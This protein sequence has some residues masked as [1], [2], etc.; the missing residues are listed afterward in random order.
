[1]PF[2]V[3]PAQGV[4][5]ALP[6]ARTGMC[7]GAE[8][9]IR[10]AWPSLLKKK[11]KCKRGKIYSSDRCESLILGSTV[12]KIIFRWSFLSRAA[13][14]LQCLNVFLK[15]SFLIIPLNAVNNPYFREESF[16]N[17]FSAFLLL[18]DFLATEMTWQLDHHGARHRLC[19]DSAA[20]T[21]LSTAPPCPESKTWPPSVLSSS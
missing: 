11:G 18:G 8:S 7:V 21:G 20:L 9:L 2:A 13:G 3:Y 5:L 15:V 10:Q 14:S 6:G 12:W 1:M 17:P 16:R 19:A 4:P